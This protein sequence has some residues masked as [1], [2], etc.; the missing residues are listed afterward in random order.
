MNEDDKNYYIGQ[1][2]F[3]MHILKEVPKKNVIRTRLSKESFMMGRLINRLNPEEMK[4][5]LAY[6]KSGGNP[7]DSLF[8]AK[9]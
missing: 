4:D 6:M 3:A 5:L 2:P 7:N 8:V 9:K 1:N